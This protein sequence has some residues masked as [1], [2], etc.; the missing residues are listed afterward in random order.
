MHMY[1]TVTTKHFI[2]IE[3]DFISGENLACHIV[4][5][6]TSPLALMTIWILFDIVEGVPNMSGFCRLYI[7][8]VQ[9]DALQLLWGSDLDC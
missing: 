9:C 3:T 8:S 2:L 1:N 5:L 7:A 4:H 6:V